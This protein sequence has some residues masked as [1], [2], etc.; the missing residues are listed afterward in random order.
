M[1]AKFCFRPTAISGSIFEVSAIS[2]HLRLSISSWIGSARIVSLVPHFL[3]LIFYLLWISFAWSGAISPIWRYV[4]VVK[5]FD[6]YIK[7]S[8]VEPC[9][10]SS[11]C[12]LLSA[13]PNRFG[14]FLV[15]QSSIVML[16][17]TNFCRL[18]DT[19]IVME[20]FSDSL[21]G[22][23]SDRLALVSKN[24]QI[25]NWPSKRICQTEVLII[26]NWMRNHQSDGKPLVVR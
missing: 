23:C 9:A 2:H 13:W 5:T 3:R 1:C 25:A 8:D 18:V 15:V 7:F 22:A 19:K 10:S 20:I 4:R 21:F 14:I 16:S 6:W 24:C 11:L 17:L 26:P 12:L